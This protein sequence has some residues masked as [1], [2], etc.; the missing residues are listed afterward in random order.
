MVKLKICSG[1]SWPEV[2][3]QPDPDLHPYKKKLPNAW[4]TDTA[5]ITFCMTMTP[6]ISVCVQIEWIA[7]PEHKQKKGVRTCLSDTWS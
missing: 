2:R 1:S 4:Y 3:N 7:N 6:P 5:S